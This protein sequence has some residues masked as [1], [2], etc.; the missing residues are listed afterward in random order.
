MVAIAIISIAVVSCKKD[1]NGSSASTLKIAL[2]KTSVDIFKSESTTITVT[3]QSNADVTKECTFTANGVA[4]AT[5]VFAP[6]AVGTYSIIASRNG[7][8][9]SEISLTAINSNTGGGGGGE[10]LTLSLNKTTLSQTSW[11]S[12]TFTV[13]NKSN[14]DVTDLCSFT[15]NGVAVQNNFTPNAGVF[16]IIAKQGAITSNAQNVTVTENMI[17]TFTKKTYMEDFT[18][19]WCGYCP[20]ASDKM[21]KYLATHPLSLIHI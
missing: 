4:I 12:V 6:S 13:K 10:T 16:E 5:N 2:S 9:S 3:D 11:D 17:S 1:E 7:V 19:S 15:A 21:D 20:R 18:G 8:K 14:V